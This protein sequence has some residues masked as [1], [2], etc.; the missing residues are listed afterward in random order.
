MS[1]DPKVNRRIA[2]R[3]ARV[4]IVDPQVAGARMLAALLRDIAPINATL[5]HSAPQALEVASNLNPTLIIV[6]HG[7]GEIDALDFTRRLRRSP[8]DA[9]ATPVILATSEATTA[10]LFGARDAG[11]HEFLRRPYNVGDLTRRIV[12]V[13][14]PRPWI[15]AE[16]YVGPDRRR[17][18]SAEY[19]GPRKRRGEVRAAESK[20]RFAEAAKALIAAE[21]MLDDNPGEAARLMKAQTAI[22]QEAT[23]GAPASTLTAA[24]AD[25]ATWLLRPVGDGPLARGQTRQKLKAL[26][27]ALAAAV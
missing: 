26:L 15:E 12:A 9:R 13:L 19:K 2:E 10:I 14:P 17:F 22:L 24:A 27:A 18:N 6:A 5:A 25:L 1:V 20:L 7:A 3:L 16:T 8:I 23:K 21:A 11:V 4:L